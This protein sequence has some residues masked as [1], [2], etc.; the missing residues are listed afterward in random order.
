MFT[1]N[2]SHD[3]INSVEGSG[4]MTGIFEIRD[5]DLLE[6]ANLYVDTFNAPPIFDRWTV[7]TAYNRLKDICNS[8][9]FVGL[10]YVEDGRIKAA[11]FGNCEQWFEGRHFTLREMFVSNYSQKSGIGTKVL[12]AL[13]LK[14][15]DFDVR[16]IILFTLREE[17]D[18][19]YIK[20]GFSHMDF[21][22]M[23]E[24]EI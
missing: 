2:P 18:S 3:T 4:T 13:E 1:L 14:L 22:T 12:Q 21:M 8:A 23:M 10:K 11:V 5:E 7:H 6:C 19:F 17:T 9:N 15:K 20:N 24:K 16:T